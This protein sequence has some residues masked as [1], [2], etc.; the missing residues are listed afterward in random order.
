MVPALGGLDALV[1]TGGV[2]ENSARTRAEAARRLAPLGVAV[3]DAASGAGAGDRDIG[4]RGAAVR[5]L[6][7]HAREDAIIARAVREA[8]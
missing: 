6:V 7:V 8:T 1:F 5:T 3:D 2:G 4:A